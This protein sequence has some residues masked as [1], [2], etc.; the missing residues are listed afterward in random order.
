[1]GG[2]IHRPARAHDPCSLFSAH[3]PDHNIRLDGST[4]GEDVTL[5]LRGLTPEQAARVL[6]SLT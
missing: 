1:V 4:Y 2:S 3:D 6:Q 5:E